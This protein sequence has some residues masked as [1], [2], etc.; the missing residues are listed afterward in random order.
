MAATTTTAEL[1]EDKEAPLASK[2]FTED[3]EAV[4]EEEEIR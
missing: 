3:R 4:V 1:P 2:F